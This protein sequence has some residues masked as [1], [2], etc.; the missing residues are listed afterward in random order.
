MSTSLDAKHRD[1]V[2]PLPAD[3]IRPK[4][5]VM[6]PTYNCSRFLGESLR[7]VLLQAP[8]PKQ[9]QIEVVDDCSFDDPQRVVAEIGG[10]RVGF[11]R[12]SRNVGHIANFHTC[13]TRAQGEIVHLLHGDDAIRP[14]FYE[15]IQRGF[16]AD[17]AVGAAFCRPTFIDAA[18]KELSVGR[19]MQRHPGPIDDAVACLARQQQIMTPCIAVRRD[20]YEKLGGFDRRLKCSEDWE[21]WVRIASQFPVWY[22]PEPLA[23]YRMHSHSN[24]GRHVRSAGDMAYT[25]MAIDIFESYLPRGVAGEVATSARRTYALSAL[26]M[27]RRLL[28]DGEWS[29]C[30]AQLRE[31]FRFDPSFRTLGRALR[32]LA[33]WGGGIVRPS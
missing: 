14:G 30:L 27:G 29:G 7:R 13:L 19:E 16:D 20:V 21:M 26:D 10:D 17:P 3:T 28:K 5:S 32:L 23:L 9:M 25:R 33:S 15:R 12:Q 11:V 22:D 8:G 1:P 4:W 2:P 6:I 18:G 24:T 31:A